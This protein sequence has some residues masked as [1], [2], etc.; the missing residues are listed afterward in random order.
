[1]LLAI[2]RGRTESV[3][4]NIK[5]YDGGDLTYRV[6][7]L[8]FGV[9]TTPLQ[10]PRRCNVPA[11]AWIAVDVFLFGQAWSKMQ[12][13]ILR[14]E[15]QMTALKRYKFALA[16]T[17]KKITL[18]FGAKLPIVNFSVAVNTA[19]LMTVKNC[20]PATISLP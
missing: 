15:E 14:V 7:K 13:L 20:K 6:Y 2:L 3:L 19:F 12:P 8:E 4:R 10:K 9:V 18:P 5:R 16:L 17:R 1:M 11:M